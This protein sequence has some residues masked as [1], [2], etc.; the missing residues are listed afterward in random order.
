MGRLAAKQLCVCVSYQLA[1]SSL[2]EERS[3]GEA[4]LERSRMT[5]LQGDLQSLMNEARKQGVDIRKLGA[6]LSAP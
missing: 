2:D 1:L 5:S 3:R 6:A 4:E